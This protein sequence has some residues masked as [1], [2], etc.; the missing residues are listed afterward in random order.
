MIFSQ[1]RKRLTGGCQCGAVRYSL[2][3]SPIRASICH[4]RMCQKASGQPFMA[5]AFVKT[6]DL[7]WTRGAPSVFRS[8]N[9]AERGFCKGC[10]TPLTYQFHPEDI[11]VMSGTLDDPTVAPPTEQYG[12][13]SMMPWCTT[14]AN[15]PQVR[16]EDDQGADV[17]A[18]FVN[19]QHP[20]HDT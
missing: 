5:F 7:H 8:S 19:L 12:I 14:I 3:A 1:W 20:D 18:R 4:C 6:P 10:G 9:M 13:E 2:S 15:L 11:A 17:A 16:T